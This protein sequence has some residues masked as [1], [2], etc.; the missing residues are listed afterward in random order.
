[1]SN[2]SYVEQA[3][4]FSKSADGEMYIAPNFQVKEFACNDGSDVVIIHPYI[5]HIC[6]IVR[7]KFNMPFKPNSAYRTI[8]HNTAEGGSTK[9]NHI[10]GRAVDIPAKNGVTPKQ[11]YDYVNI[12]FGDWGELGIYSWGIHV[13]IQD[14]KERFTDSSYK[15]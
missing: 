10:Y 12:L 3:M 9:S 8:A 13:G 15:G 6:Q 11:L 1:M 2:V 5:P 4:V 14:N 7:N